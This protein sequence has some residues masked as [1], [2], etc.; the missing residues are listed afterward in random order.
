MLLRFSFA[1]RQSDS[2]GRRRARTCCVGA[3]RLLD[4]LIVLHRREEPIKHASD[5]R[6]VRLLGFP[7]VRLGRIRI[8]L[9]RFLGAVLA[10]CFGY[11]YLGMST[12]VTSNDI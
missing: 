2:D 1:V 12:S 6:A 3:C 7:E 8:V 5:V 11:R 9:Q 10:C 4:R